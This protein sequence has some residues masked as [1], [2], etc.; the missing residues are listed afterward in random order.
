[1]TDERI[2][3]QFAI[4]RVYVKDL[5]F[6]SPRALAVFQQNWQPKVD[7]QLNTS[8][9]KVD[10]QR[11]EVVLR[12][13]VEAK[14]VDDVA[15]IVELEQAGLF[16]VEG[17]SGPALDQV[18]AVTCPNVLFPYARETVDS[19]MVRGT[20]PPFSLAP[21]NFELLYAKAMEQKTASGGDELN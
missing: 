13:T 20:M 18:L 6:E 10:D 3:V 16:R 9:T 14:I 17:P 7:V 15:V 1:M 2:N 21:V 19:M 5:S 4:E 8:A 11:F 12:V